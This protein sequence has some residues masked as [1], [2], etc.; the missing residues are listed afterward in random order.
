MR[1]KLTKAD[2]NECH[3][4]IDELVELHKKTDPSLNKKSEEEKLEL[5]YQALNKIGR[6][7][8][9]LTEWAECQIFGTYYKIGNSKERC[10]SNE[11]S[12]KHD[13]EL[14][15]YSETP[16]DFLTTDANLQAERSAM[17]CILHNLFGCY[18]RMGWR[19]SLEQALYALNE[20]Q[21]EGILTPSKT[22]QK[23]KA[24]DLQEL[25]WAAVKHAYI[26]HGVGIKKAAAQR[27]VEEKCGVK[28]GTLKKWEKQLLSN[29]RGT[30]EHLKLVQIGAGIF[31]NKDLNFVE[32]TQE[33]I[34][35]YLEKNDLIQFLYDDYLHN[36]GDIG[37]KNK[38][39]LTHSLNYI[40][41][42]CL[43]LQ[44][45]YPLEGLKQ[46]L[47]NAGLRIGDE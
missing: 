5:S 6:I 25:K 47:L 22:Y 9:L 33:D 21:V 4:L 26:I 2:I 28:D 44:E 46:K 38:K 17:A 29:K 31:L 34:K 27:K 35:E 15:W 43:K 20:G 8:G 18:G 16:E 3:S 23:G 42:S 45:D 14:M 24:Y 10:I 40:F 11:E 36:E 32:K 13:N 7:G 19:L 12:N 1:R 41:V 39:S 37:I 30:K